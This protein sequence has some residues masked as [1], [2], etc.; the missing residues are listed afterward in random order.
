MA[1][2]LERHRERVYADCRYDVDDR[3]ARLGKIGRSAGRG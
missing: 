1:M 2:Q 3:D